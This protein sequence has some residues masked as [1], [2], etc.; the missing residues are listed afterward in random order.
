MDMLKNLSS[1]EV[2]RLRGRFGAR[3]VGATEFCEILKRSRG[4]G[5]LKDHELLS[6]FCDIDVRQ[7]GEVSWEQFTTYTIDHE[8]AAKHEVRAD[9]IRNYELESVFYDEIQHSI[10]GLTYLPRIDKVAKLIHRGQQSTIKLCNP[11]SLEAYLVTPPLGAPPLCM[12]LVPGGGNDTV[13]AACSDMSVG[14]YELRA[15]AYSRGVMPQLHSVKLD[16]T[17]MCFR[18]FPRFSRLFSGSRCGMLNVWHTPSGWNQSGSTEAPEVVKSEHLHHQAIADILM[19]DNNALTASLDATIKITDMVK[20]VVKAELKGHTQGVRS[21]RYSQ[22]YSLLV[23]AGF[24]Y[25]PYLWMFQMTELKPWRLEDKQRPHQAML[26][27][28]AAIE[29]T[30]QLVSVDKKGMMKVWDVRTFRCV[31]T[32]MAEMPSQQIVHAGTERSY[33]TSMCALPTHKRVAVCG[34]TLSV[35]RYSATTRPD[36]ADDKMVCVVLYNAHHA[37]F[38]TAHSR[39]VKVWDS[40]G[41]LTHQQKDI[42]PD[43]A[44]CGCLD[45]E[46]RRF[47]LGLM[48]GLICGFSWNTMQRFMTFAEHLGHEVTSLRYLSNPRELPQLVTLSALGVWSV[49]DAE[50]SRPFHIKGLSKTVQDEGSQMSCV[51]ARDGVRVIAVGTTAGSVFSCDT[52]AHNLLGGCARIRSAVRCLTFIGD[53]STLVFTED[54]DRSVHIAC[55]KVPWLHFSWKAASSRVIARCMGIIPPEENALHLDGMTKGDPQGVGKTSPCLITCPP[56]SSYSLDPTYSKERGQACIQVSCLAFDEGA[57]ELYTGDE[58]GWIV[59]YSLRELLLAVQGVDVASMDARNAVEGIRSFWKKVTIARM[60]LAHHDELRSF[61]LIQ[62]KQR[63]ATSSFDV[64]VL[65]W[66]FSGICLASLQQGRSVQVKAQRPSVVQQ[67]APPPSATTAK[68]NKILASFLASPFKRKK[69]KVWILSFSI[70]ANFL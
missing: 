16:E 45:K 43:D 25:D 55:A 68:P 64:Q 14:F 5:R 17:Q 54:H 56:I 65:V 41:K 42:T 49:P 66:T 47:Y 3:K 22:E 61:T 7:D 30:P 32:T 63:L 38:L 19:V 29:S 20:G 13:V 58:K 15:P 28:I 9:D 57:Q 39:D 51:A 18:W 69:A 4:G 23:S 37:A 62:E 33:I 60:W 10:R 70:T 46:G 40:T 21:L 44:T 50:D 12:E 34:R 11:L 1:P 52:L 67:D 53:T 36:H 26:M 2:D 24:E 35:F 27:G 8:M 6:L 59:V 48:N 31:Q